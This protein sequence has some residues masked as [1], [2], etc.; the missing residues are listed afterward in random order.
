MSMLPETA[1]HLWD[2]LEA[3]R[4]ARD[5]TEGIVYHEFTGD[6]MRRSAVERQLEVLGEALNRIRRVD[7]ET[8]QR[9][10]GLAQIV[11]MRNIIAHDY[12]SIDCRLVWEAAT[13]R[14]PDLVA[15]L[16]LLLDEVSPDPVAE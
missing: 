4:A 3:A 7:S 16:A 11:G 12:G 13:T 1:A 2:A 9:I 10:P 5:F 15:V 6:L 14:V 8:S